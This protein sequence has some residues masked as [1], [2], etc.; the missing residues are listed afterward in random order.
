MYTLESCTLWSWWWSW[1]DTRQNIQDIQDI[2]LQQNHHCYIKLPIDYLVFF[3]NISTMIVKTFSI[4]RSDWEDCFMKQYIYD[5][6]IGW[7]S[8]GSTGPRQ[9]IIV[10]THV[11]FDWW[12][13]LFNWVEVRWIGWKEFKLHSTTYSSIRWCP[14]WKISMSTNRASTISLILEDL[15]MRQLSITMT[16]FGAG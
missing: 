14:I 8:A 3:L 4:I 15:W 2:D 9:I 16:E 7:V 5:S 12:K 10:A 13:G 1:R 11:R 6:F